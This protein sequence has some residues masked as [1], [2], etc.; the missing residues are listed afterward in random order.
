MI[1]D[2]LGIPETECTT[3]HED[4]F[5]LA[6]KLHESFENV[7]DEIGESGKLVLPL[8]HYQAFMV[9]TLSRIEVTL[10]SI[11]YL[12]AHGHMQ[13]S[14]ILLRGILECKFQ[15]GFMRR[16]IENLSQQWFDYRYALVL[17]SYQRVKQSSN[18]SKHSSKV[19]SD[20]D[21]LYS[22]HKS[23]IDAFT[24]RNSERVLD[25]MYWQNW[26][27]KSI[28]DVAKA[29]GLK[30]DY[31]FPYEH[32]CDYVHPN[33]LNAS[34][35]VLTSSD[36][37]VTGIGPVHECKRKDMELLFPTM[38]RAIISCLRWFCSDFDLSEQ[39]ELSNIEES[40]LQIAKSNSD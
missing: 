20:A 2:D 8:P 15:W 23:E 30:N 28:K 3:E 1:Q 13:D 40:L 14:F 31:D 9:T 11:L 5:E 18:W 33:P 25:R 4:L 22:E 21:E 36:G 17:K 10:I 34:K 32:C 6:Y 24:R 29:A 19:Q 26:T 35:Y 12:A 39:S 7:K 38:I 27:R 37:E 16:D